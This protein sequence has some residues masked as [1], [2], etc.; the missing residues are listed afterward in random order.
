MLR[1]PILIFNA[2]SNFSN[3]EAC[4]NIRQ[5]WKTLKKTK[6]IECWDNT[7][8]KMNF[9]IKDFCSKC[10]QIDRKLW[11]WSHL[12]ETAD[13]VTFA[14]EMLNEKLRFLRSAKI[15]V[16]Y[17]YFWFFVDFLLNLIF[18]TYLRKHCQS[19]CHSSLFSIIPTAI[20]LLKVNNKSTETICEN[21][22]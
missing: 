18:S 2:L 11:I 20:Y 10:D 13:L 5:N 16:S 9:S 15:L 17:G 4:C 7:A 19:I 8:Q 3:G 14:K 6:T 21:F 1:L 12:L 22:S